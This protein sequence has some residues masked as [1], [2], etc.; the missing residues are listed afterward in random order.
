MCVCI[1][2]CT[3]VDKYMHVCV[4]TIMGVKI[5]RM[6]RHDIDIANAIGGYNGIRPFMLGQ[7]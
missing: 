1:D 5:N 3:C 2:H 7:T 6:T 4:C